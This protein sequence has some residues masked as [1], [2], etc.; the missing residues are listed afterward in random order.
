MQIADE[1]L[2]YYHLLGVALPE[3]GELRTNEIE[4]DSQGR[5]HAAEIA[6]AGR[7]FEF[8]AQ[9]FDLD[10]GGEP[11]RVHLIVTR[12][13]Y[14]IDA[15]GRELVGVARQI[16]RELFE[17]LL[18][19]ELRRVNKDRNDNGVGHPAGLAHHAEMAF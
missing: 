9:S 11:G 13:E 18:R 1:F 16:A 6:R 2:Y 15:D 3:E 4:Q 12:R 8:V 17:L 14:V 5:G 7:P 10:V 19:S